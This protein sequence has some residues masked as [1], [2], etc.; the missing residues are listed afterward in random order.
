[1]LGTYYLQNSKANDHYLINSEMDPIVNEYE[2]KGNLK[3]WNVG[4]FEPEG[5][6]VRDGKVY[7]NVS[8]KRDYYDDNHKVTRTGVQ[9]IF[10]YDLAK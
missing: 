6:R 2:E 3:Y 9:Y 8:A 5:I 4:Y 10:V 1:M 7:I